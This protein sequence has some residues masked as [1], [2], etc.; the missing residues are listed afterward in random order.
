MKKQ[1]ALLL[2]LLAIFS[3]EPSAVA[4]VPTDRHTGFSNP[5][6]AGFHPDPSVCRVGDDFYL[7]T[8]TFQ[9][10]P[11]LALYHSRDL[12]NW[13]PAGHCITREDQTDLSRATSRS[14]IYAPVIRYDE[15]TFYV[16]TTNVSGGGNF[17][18][19]ATDPQGEWSD[20]IPVAVPGI[21]PSLYFED[22][23][24]Y[25]TYTY[26]DM[27]H[28]CEIDPDTGKILSDPVRIW[29]GTGGRYPEGPHIYRKD[30]WYYLL[31]S[32]GG[33]E[34]GHMITIAR[35][36]TIE[37]P[38]SSNPANPIL[39]HVFQPTQTSP[40][41]G[42]GHG[43]FVQAPDGSWWMVFLA[44]RTL[45][46]QQHHILGRET[47]LAPVRWDEGAW[48]VVNGNG[49]V[50]L[51]MDC[52]VLPLCPVPEPESTAGFSGGRPGPEWMFLRNPVEE[53][54]S[55]S[56]ESVKM[57]ASSACIDDMSVSPS[58]LARRQESMDF[59]ASVDLAG[60][61]G[62]NAEAGI[63]IYMDVDSHY[64]VF[65]RKGRDGKMYAG[66]RY[67][68]GELDHVE[69]TGPV[70]GQITLRVGGTAES[71]SFSY[72]CD[73]EDF[74]PLGKMDTSYLSSET[75]GGF[76]GV[77]I[78]MY[79]TGEKGARAEFSGFCY[80]NILTEENL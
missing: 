29:G 23:R 30:G 13:T 66:I 5:V 50:S 73:G 6:L 72:S 64:D 18:L 27:I 76:T 61:S 16:I 56:G 8:S 21:D 32:E 68:L 9:Y 47:F 2:L 1:S 67:S 46:G 44:F 48:P 39:T 63:T 20:P 59:E 45:P 57:K 7:V 65:V 34:Y 74:V 4:I 19:K 43:D 17:I 10:F 60:L 35:S 14:G 71:Y 22:G 40:V 36:R 69:T 38:Y 37:G 12:V 78:G 52:P 31:I 33:T 42:T 11:G 79:C 3:F 62:R 28:L 77:V 55:F 25:L 70:R 53:N 15:G 26:S 54:Y 80:E 49:Q 41:Q 58:F 24:C 51:E 75:S